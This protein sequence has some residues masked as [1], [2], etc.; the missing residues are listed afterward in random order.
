MAGWTLKNYSQSFVLC[1]Y[2]N[3]VLYYAKME[4]RQYGTQ[5]VSF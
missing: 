5:S 1:V 4:L 3:W 2:L